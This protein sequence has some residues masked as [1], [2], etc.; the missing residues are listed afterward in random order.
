MWGHLSRG[1][2]ELRGA[3]ETTDLTLCCPPSECDG[4]HSSLIPVGIA[5]LKAFTSYWHLLDPFW[6]QLI[7]SHL[8]WFEGQKTAPEAVC[9]HGRSPSGCGSNA[10][11]LCS[12]NTGTLAKFGMMP[13]L[14]ET[15]LVCFPRA[16][17]RC[18][19]ASEIVACLL[20][21]QSTI[22]I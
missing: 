11:K 4:F 22:L 18:C 10:T 7:G 5:S 17:N 16:C 8:N 14:P 6:V 2:S 9:P 15:I 19:V 20:L 21:L 13:L 12:S 3:C 1:L